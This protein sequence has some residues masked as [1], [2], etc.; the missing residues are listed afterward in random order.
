M[1]RLTG[2]H[3]RF[4]HALQKPS[5]GVKTARS[6]LPLQE[7]LRLY[8]TAQPDLFVKSP[9]PA[10]APVQIAVIGDSGS[11]N[12]AQAATAKL[13]NTL[14]Q[15]T[16]LDAVLML[17]DNVY[18]FDREKAE[19]KTSSD[20]FESRLYAPYK[21]LYED[22]VKFYPVLGNHDVVHGEADAQLAFMGSPP[23]YSHRIGPAEIFVIDTTLY[24]PGYGYVPKNLQPSLRQ[25]QADVQTV[26]LKAALKRSNAPIKL[27]CGH[28]PVYAS[29]DHR[30]GDPAIKTFE[31]I[32][33]PVLEQ[34]G[35]QMYLS[36]HEHIYERLTDSKGLPHIVLG[37]SGRCAERPIQSRHAL[38]QLLNNQ[39]KQHHV[40]LMTLHP[41]GQMA[42]KTYNTQ[43]ELVDSGVYETPRP[44][45]NNKAPNN[46]RP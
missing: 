14:H 45:P 44:K 30:V 17:G 4:L 38:S 42:F 24:L 20:Y 40:M 27:V 39:P 16:P 31:A 6:V 5:F 13:L 15:T 22:D 28:Y 7:K 3:S 18:V 43:A 9:R 25:K 8:G 10:D 11:G 33:K 1:M 32:M 19:G 34:S 35:A 36:G 12:G 23:F 2:L 46:K 21:A 29:G 37:T 26:W 41:S